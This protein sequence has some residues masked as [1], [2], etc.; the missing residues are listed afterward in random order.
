MKPPRWITKHRPARPAGHKDYQEIWD[1]NADG[2]DAT[3]SS[4]METCKVRW[5]APP[6]V[7]AWPACCASALHASNCRPALK[8]M[9]APCTSVQ[10][11]FDDRVECRNAL[12]KLSYLTGVKDLKRDYLPWT[13]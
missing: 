10:S 6:A 9:A 13:R 7:L 4:N 12:S 5:H 3:D 8:I 1:G 2:F 11:W